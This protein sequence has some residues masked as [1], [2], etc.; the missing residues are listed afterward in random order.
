MLGAV[1]LT[2]SDWV[3]PNVDR[4]KYS[5]INGVNEL[6]LGQLGDS[7]LII[8]SVRPPPKESRIGKHFTVINLKEPPIS[9]AEIAE[10]ELPTTSAPAKQLRK[11]P[12][13][14]DDNNIGVSFSSD[15]S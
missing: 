4:Q 5:I 8:F 6:G 15:D 9:D 7:Q 10:E 1:K 3:W 14:T 11:S 2:D 12:M 13:L